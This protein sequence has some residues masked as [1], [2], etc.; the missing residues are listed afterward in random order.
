MKDG[1]GTYHTPSFH[2]EGQWCNNKRQGVGTIWWSNG[3]SQK[4]EFYND[5]AHG[6]CVYIDA[7]G[8]VLR[9]N[10]LPVLIPI[11]FVKVAIFLVLLTQAVIFPLSF[12]P[13]Y[14]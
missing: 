1:V 4:G 14:V 8:T 9:S 3:A 5:L 11:E 7:N 6:K 2:Y 12:F 10:M 13:Q